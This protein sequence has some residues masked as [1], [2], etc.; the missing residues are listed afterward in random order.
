M[1]L[2]SV[3]RYE[4]YWVEDSALF[5]LTNPPRLKLKGKLFTEGRSKSGKR[6]GSQI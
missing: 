6:K 5:Y 3:V 4:F 2:K 1:E